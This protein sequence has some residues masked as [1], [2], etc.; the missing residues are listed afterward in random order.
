MLFQAQE[1]GIQLNVDRIKPLDLEQPK[2]VDSMTLMFRLLEQ[3]PLTHRRYRNGVDDGELE[4]FVLYSRFHM[5][6]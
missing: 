5:P 3:I 2:V 1:A 4:L 6:Y